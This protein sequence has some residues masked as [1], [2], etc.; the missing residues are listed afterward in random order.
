MAAGSEWQMMVDTML[1]QQAPSCADRSATAT[2]VSAEDSS[3]NSSSLPPSQ[4]M[5][6]TSW[7]AQLLK[8]HTRN[9]R[10]VNEQLETISIISGCTGSFAE[11]EVLKVS[12]QH[13]PRFGVG[14]CF[15]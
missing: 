14:G 9:S 12:C 13:L 3:T 10:A 7:W 15:T 11:A 4:N 8:S 2:E 1:A 6:T 5:R